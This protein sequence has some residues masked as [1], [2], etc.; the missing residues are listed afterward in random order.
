MAERGLLNQTKMSGQKRRLGD[1][2][3]QIAEL[4]AAAQAAATRLQESSAVEDRLRT[5]VRESPPHTCPLACVAIAI[6]TPHALRNAR[7]LSHRCACGCDPNP[8]INDLEVATSMVQ[9]RLT[10]QTSALEVARTEAEDLQNQLTGAQGEMRRMQARVAH[11]TL[12]Y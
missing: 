11:A 12:L 10:T 4:Q 3:R 7:L 2:A 8:Q 9:Q 5:Q 1:Q 6:A